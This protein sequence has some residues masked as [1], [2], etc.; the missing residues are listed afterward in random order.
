MQQGGQQQGGSSSSLGAAAPWGQQQQQGGSS[1]GG[2]RGGSS[3]GG[4]SRG[5]SSRGAS[6]WGHSRGAA[7]GGQQQGQQQGGSSSSLGDSDTPSELNL[8]LKLFVLRGLLVLVGMPLKRDSPSRLMLVRRRGG[9]QHSLAAP[10]AGS[11]D[12]N[13]AANPAYPDHQWV[14]QLPCLMSLPAPS[15]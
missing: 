13:P 7:A 4:S 5:G 14:P 12:Q 6:A 2:S 3:R 11:S 9:A 15:P 1:K 10:L 8:L